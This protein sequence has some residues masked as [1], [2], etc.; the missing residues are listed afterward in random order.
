MKMSGLT[1]RIMLVG[2]FGIGTLAQ[3]YK[4]SFEEVGC[5]VSCFDVNSSVEKH[6]RFGA[7]GRKFNLYA[8]VGAWIRKANREMVVRARELT[9]QVVV[10]VGNCPATTGALAQIKASLEV[11][12]VHIW[13]DTLLNLDSS[14]IECLPLYD[15]ECVY[16]QSAVELMKRL[17][18]GRPVWTPLA[19]DPSIHSVAECTTSEVVEYGA[20]VTFI[21]GW[22]PERE[23]LL[24]ALTRFNLKIWG[25]D[26]GRR[27]RNNSAIMKA[28][29]GRALRGREFA[30]AVTSS[31][32]NLNIIDQTNYPA[33]NMRFFEIPCAGGLQLSSPCPEMESEFK[34]GETTFYYRDESELSAHIRDLLNDSELCRKVKQAAY[35]KVMDKHTYIHRAKQILGLTAHL[36]LALNA[37]I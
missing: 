23:A 31:K 6:C 36:H 12:L 5:E 7:L 19:G 14:L 30:K 25:P 17:G 27:C 2:H 28:W 1:R 26:W 16:S 3:S 34:H 10:V 33:A 4:V 37:N 18:A 8:P 35:M 32:I 21:G 22:R 24:S 9:P 11:T 29:Q 13:P 15:L 20:E